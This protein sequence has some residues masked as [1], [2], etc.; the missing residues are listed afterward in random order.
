MFQVQVQSAFEQGVHQQG[1][2]GRGQGKLRYDAVK[3]DEFVPPSLMEDYQLAHARDD[4]GRGRDF[5]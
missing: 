4:G 1:V 3:P 5:F 2:Q